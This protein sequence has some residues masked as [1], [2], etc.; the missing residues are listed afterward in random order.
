[1]NHLSRLFLLVPA[2]GTLLLF[3]GTAQATLINI[4]VQG[5]WE[6]TNPNAI[7]NGLLLGDG[8]TFLFQATY[9]DATLFNGDDGVTASIDPAINPGTSLTITLPHLAGAPNPLVFTHD[10]HVDIGFAPTAQIEFDGSDAITD[11]GPFRNFEATIEFS[12]NGDQ[13]TFDT[14]F[15]FIQEETNLNNES[16]GFQLV[17]VGA[18]SDHLEI[19]P[20]P[21]TGLLFGGGLLGLA[22]RARRR[23]P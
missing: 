22:A 12:F 20:E 4:V 8:D 19:I 11:P 3:A 17:A 10:D 5:T 23:K 2:V 7:V 1:M 21:S 14:S 9:D 15:H 6:A 16:E 18:G 13:Y